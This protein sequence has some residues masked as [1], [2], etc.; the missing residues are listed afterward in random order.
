MVRERGGADIMVKAPIPARRTYMGEITDSTRWESFIPRDGD[1]VVSTPPKAGTTWTQAI[2]ALLI[3]GNPEVDAQTSMKSPWIDINIRDMSEV[4]ERLEAQDHRRQVKTHT[5]FDGIPF[6]RELRYI[7]VFRHPIDIHFS[8]RKHTKNVEAGFNSEFVPDDLS[9]SFRIFLEGEHH[10]AASL[11]SIINHYR[12]TL[13][14]EPRENLLRVHYADMIRDL[15]DSI[16]QIASHV[17]ISH[18]PDLMAKLVKA[19]TF[20]SMKAN[21]DRFAP[22][23]GQGFW[24]NDSGFFDSASSN[25]WHGKLSETDLTAYDERIS[26]LLSSEERHWLEWGSNTD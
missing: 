3:S 1:I 6:W 5:P 24:R 12:T 23:A 16:C 21:A 10:E 8:F 22:S 18:S 25:K 11:W 15:S 13:A 14:L 20:D 9:E 19:A 26:S 2:V 17:G 7:A 4:V